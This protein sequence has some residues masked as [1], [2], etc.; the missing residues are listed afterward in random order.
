MITFKTARLTDNT[1]IEVI[2]DGTKIAT[3]NA[4]DGVNLRGMIIQGM[5]DSRP[6]L[7]ERPEGDRMVISFGHI[8]TA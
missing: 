2:E 8:A 5:A 4:G 3:I 7:F 6:L 1:T